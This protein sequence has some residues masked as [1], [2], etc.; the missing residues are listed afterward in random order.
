MSPWTGEA[1]ALA[2]RIAAYVR[3]ALVDGPEPEPFDGLAVAVHRWQRAFDPVLDAL[4]TTPADAVRGALDVPA[5]P[6]SLF[7][8]LPVG[9]VGDD[10][11]AVVFRTS[12]TTGGGRGTHR[13]RSSVLYDLGAQ[14]WHRRCVPDAPT[15]VLALLTDPTEAPD[16]S[17]SHMVAG[18]GEVR[19]ALTA[20]GL[21]TD[22]VRRWVGEATAPVYVAATAFAL[23]ELLDEGPPRLP[24]G[25]VVMVTGGFKGRTVRLSDEQLYAEVQGQ[26]APE[27]LVTEYGMTELSSQL[28]GAPG[29]P[30]RPPR[31]LRVVAVDPATGA[32]RPAGDRGQLRFID[33]CN[34]DGTLAIDTMDEGV[35]APDG[36]VTLHGR[37]AGAELR[38]CSL[39]VEELW[40]RAR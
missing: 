40:D 15:D 1:A 17:L 31:W 11:A 37:L 12:G 18:F 30:Y 39:T 13:L 34:L 36:G 8:D 7:K 19:W 10:D 29:Q 16:S 20:S 26:M 27:R 21:D 5:V 28:W 2:E 22:A 35:V 3:A 32:P 38:G 33:L 14:G 4:A 6:V 25:S 23:A 9:T 24:P